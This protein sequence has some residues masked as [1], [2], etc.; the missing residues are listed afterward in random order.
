MKN[1]LAI[2][3]AFYFFLTVFTGPL[4][5]DDAHGGWAEGSGTPTAPENGN[6]NYVVSSIDTTQSPN[7]GTFN[8]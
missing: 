5:S 7:G 8:D 6:H 3:G 4:S 2:A 1:K